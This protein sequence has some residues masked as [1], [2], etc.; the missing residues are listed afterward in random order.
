MC[1]SMWQPKDQPLRIYQASYHGLLPETVVVREPVVSETSSENLFLYFLISPLLTSWTYFLLGEQELLHFKK[2]KWKEDMC[3]ENFLLRMIYSFTFVCVCHSFF[4]LQEQQVHCKIKKL[5]LMSK[6]RWNCV[7]HFKVFALNLWDIL[8]M[9]FNL[10]TSYII[11][12]CSHF[13]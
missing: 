13:M 4:S 12:F 7:L 6:V 8:Y 10:H 2:S 5:H 3:K 11:I 9:S 1:C